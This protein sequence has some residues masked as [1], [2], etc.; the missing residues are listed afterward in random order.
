MRSCVFGLVLSLGL[1][2]SEGWARESGQDD[3][4]PSGARRIA[5]TFDKLP[6]MEPLSF[7][8]P[9]ELASMILRALEDH[10]VKA[11]GFVVEEK[12]ANRPDAVIVLQDWV[13]AGHFLGNNTWGYV[14][15]NEVDEDEFWWQ[16]AEGLKTLRHFVKVGQEEILF[17]YPM[18]HE[19]S[20]EG[21]KRRIANLLREAGFHAVPA[22]VF[23][24]DYEFNFVFRDYF[25]DEEALERLKVVYLETFQRALEYAESEA[26]LVFGRP[27]P[28]ILQ[29]HP[30]LATAHFLA[31][32][33]GSL[34]ERGYVFADLREVLKDSA[35]AAEENYVGPLGLSFID[36][37]AATRG[38][39]YDQGPK[40]PSRREI[41]ARV[42]WEGD[43][44]KP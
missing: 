5:V 29:L 3:S 34:G 24:A 10:R 17:R 11:V 21:K 7:W 22:T 19:G 37:V 33:L 32:L 2:A 8:T 25:E 14:D 30:G 6:Y 23:F 4:E 44:G 40:F 20:T 41:A 18:L 35:Y 26:E 43:G 13:K 27:I 9:R 1:A 42:A 31:D 15:L 36:R 12:I 16:T 28:Q 39:P 38:L